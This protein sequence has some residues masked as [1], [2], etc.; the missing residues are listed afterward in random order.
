MSFRNQH[1]P[2]GLAAALTLLWAK[3]NTRGGRNRNKA[4]KGA[5]ATQHDAE[6]RRIRDGR[7]KEIGTRYTPARTAGTT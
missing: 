3:R 5:K 4:A 1:G 7:P 6:K 2:G